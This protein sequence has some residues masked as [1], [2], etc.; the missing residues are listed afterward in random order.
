MLFKRNAFFDLQEIDS[1]RNGARLWLASVRVTASHSRN[2]NE[3]FIFGA[4]WFFS[5]SRTIT[6]ALV[7]RAALAGDRNFDRDHSFGKTANFCV[8]SFRLLFDTSGGTN[9]F[10]TRIR[11]V[12]PFFAFF[13]L[14]QTDEAIFRFNTLTILEN[15]SFR[16]I[17]FLDNLTVGRLF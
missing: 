14:S 5:A 2:D 10:D 11:F 1:C 12:S 6:L 7:V 16:T 8:A 3:M 15:K 17:A 9:V 13:V 4:C